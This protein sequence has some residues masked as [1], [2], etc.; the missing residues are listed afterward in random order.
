MPALIRALPGAPSGLD[1]AKGVDSTYLD[2]C[3][4][5]PAQDLR[6]TTSAPGDFSVNPKS[7]VRWALVQI[8]ALPLAGSV[9][10]GICMTTPSLSFLTCKMGIDKSMSLPGLL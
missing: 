8:P 10:L 3:T 9:V 6:V 4:P 2:V 7:G 1:V 5:R